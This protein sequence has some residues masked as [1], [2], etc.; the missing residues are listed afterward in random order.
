[1][2]T[3]REYLV[4][5]VRKNYNAFEERMDDV[6]HTVNFAV[7]A[8]HLHEWVFHDNKENPDKIFNATSVKKYEEELIKR[9]PSVKEIRDLA[10]LYKHSQPTTNRVIQGNDGV[11]YH[12]YMT[13]DDHIGVPL[14]GFQRTKHDGKDIP[15]KFRQVM[16]M[17]NELF[18]EY[19]L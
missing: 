13:V 14:D 6:R 15:E 10:T 3:A 8:F 7:T 2:H 17:W 1:M 12:A 19:D 18:E 4:K 5:V 16:F 9:Y 11:E